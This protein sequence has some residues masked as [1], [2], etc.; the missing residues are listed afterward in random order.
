MGRGKIEHETKREREKK[1]KKK[2]DFHLGGNTRKREQSVAA[3]EKIANEERE[4]KGLPPS[5][6]LLRMREQRVVTFEK[7]VKE[8]RTK[9]YRF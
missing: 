1:K 8:E 5:R 9:C 4:N 3:F 7:I 6:R 2:K